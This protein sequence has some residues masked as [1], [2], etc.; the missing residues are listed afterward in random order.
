[1]RGDGLPSRG[2]GNRV[3]AFRG[4]GPMP[5][6]CIDS[7]CACLGSYH[8]SSCCPSSG[9]E[10]GVQETRGPE[11]HQGKSCS[12]RGCRDGK[13]TARALGLVMV[14][15]VMWA[16][17]P[18]QSWAQSFGRGFGPPMPSPAESEEFDQPDPL[19]STVMQWW[20]RL[21]RG[22]RDP[23]EQR[24]R[25]IF[26]QA[27]QLFL[28]K[29]YGEALRQ[30][31]SAAAWWP[32]SPL[33]EDALLMIAECYFFQDDYR[34]AYE[35]YDRLLQKYEHTRH[36]DRV[37]QRLFSIAQYWL[38][39]H[40]SNPRPVLLPSFDRRRPMFDTEGHALKA[41]EQIWLKD[42]TGPLA[43][44]AVFLVANTHFAARRWKQAD[45]Y[46]T[47]LR[48]DYPNSRYLLWAYVL[49]LQ[50]KLQTYQG[51]GYDDT[52]LK[53]AE[54]LA[55]I[56]LTQFR[57]ELG[58]QWS[59]VAQTQ[60]RIQ[61]LKAQRDYEM[62]EYYARG[63]YYKAAR[64]Y[65]HQVLRRFPQTR[66]AQLAQRRLEQY[67]G[68]PDEPPQRFEWLARL[69]P[70]DK[71]GPQPLVPSPGAAGSGGTVARSPARRTPK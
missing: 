41:L 66:Y 33:E 1:M 50:A 49:G 52:P 55:Q 17:A 67:S 44:A 8:L 23:S 71:S 48:Q 47:Q 7:T 14:M 16:A 27:D 53:E 5:A 58:E 61:N 18:G 62:A 26:A 21:A 4:F 6:D 43:D 3:L 9:L 19:T 35:A 28:Q 57:G 64:Y 25:Q 37:M 12:G 63:G 2:L 34:S 10:V 46:Y 24:A 29:R 45:Q 11:V 51:P 36:L 15:V 22:G 70:E 20:Q 65:Y 69:F 13:A 39:L 31:R 54:K 59:R 68:R 32:D 60:A 40:R 30:Y 38:Q 42:P 56:L